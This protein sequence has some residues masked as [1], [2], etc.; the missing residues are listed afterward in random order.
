[1][2]SKSW[3]SRLRG[4]LLVMVCVLA[5]TDARS[6]V[7]APVVTSVSVSPDG[8]TMT[9]TGSAFGPKAQPAPLKWD[10]FETGTVGQT[11]GGGW[12]V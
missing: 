9:I 11:L 12:D 10:T 3:R 8:T 1:M 7:A 2:K 6:Q 4:L 5:V